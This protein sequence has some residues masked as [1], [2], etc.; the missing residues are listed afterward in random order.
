MYAAES[1]DRKRQPVS[2][3]DHP[4][5]PV[6]DPRDPDHFFVFSEARYPAYAPCVALYHAVFRF[7]R[8][9]RPRR[10]IC[11]DARNVYA[12]ENDLLCSDTGR[13]LPPCER[14]KPSITKKQV[15]AWQP[16]TFMADRR[17][18]RRADCR[19]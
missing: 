17:Y 10:V 11:D 16:V 18:V 7:L 3:G 14:R 6:P 5:Y 19:G 8:G 15:A 4:Q 2:L 9:R 12:A 13:I 1:M